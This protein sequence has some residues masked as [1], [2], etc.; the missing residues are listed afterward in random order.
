MDT[1][2]PPPGDHWIVHSSPA[3]TGRTD[4]VTPWFGLWDT[5]FAITYLVTTGLVI[6]SPGT[7]TG[8]A[9]AIG[10]L[11]VA[12]IWYA[13]LG[14]TRV[15]HRVTSTGGIGF[16]IGLLVLYTVAVAG[17]VSAAWALFAVAPVLMLSL[18][19]PWQ[20]LAVA[21][22]HSVPPLAVWWLGG[23]GAEVAAIVPIPLLGM[24]SS[25]FSGL[26]ISRVI[27]QSRERACLIEALERQ[28]EQIADL[29]HQAGIAAE[30]ERLAREIHDTLAQGLTSI[31]ALSEAASCAVDDTPR[32]ARRHLELLGR[33][34]RDNLAEARD[35]VTGGTPPGLRDASLTQALRRQA[36]AVAEAGGLTVRCALDE[37]GPVL[38]MPVSVVVLRAGQELLANVTKHAGA[39]TVEVSLRHEAGA[40]RLVVADDGAGFAVDGPTTGF[41]LRGL[42]ARVGEVDGKLRVDS[43]PSVGTTVEVTIPL[44]VPGDV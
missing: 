39:D 4:T 13:T 18:P 24:V 5:Y 29:S 8:R 42:T 27:R 33:V 26:W 44:E 34:A 3:P 16:A 31:I 23:S 21:V 35:F 1:E 38:P 7:S 17:N 14:R 41:G 15:R 9:T 22:A 28:R 43:S 12:V 25:V 10:A 30:R 20:I 19:M 40:V 36:E 11:T 32:L 37:D 6:V 2:T